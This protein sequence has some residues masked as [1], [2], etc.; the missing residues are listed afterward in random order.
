MQ[1]YGEYYDFNGLPEL[2]DSLHFYDNVHL[3]QEGVEI[4]NKIVIEIL[5]GKNHS[6]QK[7][8]GDNVF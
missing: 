3:N 5:F 6:T 7:I 2:D 4:F 8:V 1:K